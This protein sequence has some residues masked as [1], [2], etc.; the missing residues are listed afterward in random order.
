MAIIRM[1]D[2]ATGNILERPEHFLE[3]FPNHFS[4]LPSQH[5]AAKATNDKKE[6]Q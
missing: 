6:N 5:A 2:Q 3:L 1:K 4:V